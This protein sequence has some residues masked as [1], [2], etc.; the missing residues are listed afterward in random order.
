M[1]IYIN[2]YIYTQI[3]SYTPN[4]DP[5]FHVYTQIK[6]VL[7]SLI[8]MWTYLRSSMSFADDAQE[9]VSMKMM[10]LCRYLQSDCP[11]TFTCNSYIWVIL[12]KG[13]P[14]GVY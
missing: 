1:H 12:R 2:I 11:I 3:V 4:I 14:E 10:L 8:F 13:G 7:L 9:K 6:Y 5:C